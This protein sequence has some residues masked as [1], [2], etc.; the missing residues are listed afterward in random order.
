M[1]DKK[2]T[3]TSPKKTSPTAPRKRAALPAA[4]VSDRAYHHGDLRAALLDA[5]EAELIENGVA[6]FSLRGTARRAGV[7]H[8]APAHHFANTGA[9][10][11]ALALRG[12]AQLSNAMEHGMAQ[13]DSSPRARLAASGKAYVAFARLNPQLFR[14]MFF[15]NQPLQ[16]PAEAPDGGT[17]PNPLGLLHSCIEAAL[18]PGASPLDVA[19]AVASSWGL[20]H[21]LSHLLIEEA[22]AFLQPFESDARLQ[23]VDRAIDQLAAGLS[24]Q[25]S[26][27]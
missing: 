7:S 25:A 10:L 6:G 9:L 2:K 13:T 21:G 18:G 17:L 4:E 3:S 20:V 26:D 15:G 16:L 14:L 12:F 23:I 1:E 27:L 5:A 22:A 24:R 8:A 19:T 11:S